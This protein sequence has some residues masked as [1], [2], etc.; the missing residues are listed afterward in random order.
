MYSQGY[1]RVRRSSDEELCLLRTH[2]EEEGSSHSDFSSSGEHLAEKVRPVKKLNLCYFL[3]SLSP[4]IVIC[5]SF[6]S[7]ESSCCYSLTLRMSFFIKP[8]TL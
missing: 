1:E 5:C 6:V 2:D 4:A 7:D 8:F 3:D